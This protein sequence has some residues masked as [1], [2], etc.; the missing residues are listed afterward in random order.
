MP[1][2]ESNIAM[3]QVPV[4]HEYFF[5]VGSP[6]TVM[7]SVWRI[8]TW[9]GKSDIYFS[10]KGSVGSFKVSLHQDGTYRIGFA[11]QFVREQR[12]RGNWNIRN[13]LTDKW[14]APEV[15]HGIQMPFCLL[16][17]G[18][19]LRAP[20]PG[21]VTK[22]PVVWLPEVP[23]NLAYEIRLYLGNTRVRDSITVNSP[24]GG[25]G[26]L[27]KRPLPDGWILVV[28]AKRGPFRESEQ[29]KVEEVR[30]K[31]IKA[32]A[33]L[34]PALVADGRLRIVAQG[35]AEDGSRLFIDMAL[36]VAPASSG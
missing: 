21:W 19:E 18:S 12:A 30:Q 22:K 32:T 2:T 5:A 8:W 33:S 29:Q 7:S 23:A 35:F 28:L 25:L 11:N 4:D 1:R 36:D 17:P 15:K 26:G 20:E 24:D 16:I 34:S 13:R 27:W 6:E 9:P 10:E 14:I 31:V 3:S